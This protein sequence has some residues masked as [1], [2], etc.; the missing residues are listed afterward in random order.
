MT[1]TKYCK[2]RPCFETLRIRYLTMFFSSRIMTLNLGRGAV[3]RVVHVGW[4]GGVAG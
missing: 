3:A 4:Q 2:V 1:M